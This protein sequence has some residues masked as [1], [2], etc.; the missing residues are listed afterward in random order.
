LRVADESQCDEDEAETGEV[1]AKKKFA[2][3][4]A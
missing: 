2:E 1:H 4:A 3:R